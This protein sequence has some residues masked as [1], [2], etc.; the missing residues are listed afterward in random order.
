MAHPMLGLQRLQQAQSALIAVESL[1]GILQLSDLKN[2][3]SLVRGQL[4][5]D[6]AVMYTSRIGPLPAGEGV[7]VSIW[8]QGLRNVSV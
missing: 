1:P 6:A 5:P 7:R 3:M 2:I 4:A 8:A